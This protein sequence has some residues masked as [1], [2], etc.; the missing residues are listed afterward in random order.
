[1][2]TFF[3]VVCGLFCPFSASAAEQVSGTN[4]LVGESQ[5]WQTGETTGYWMTSN[6]G[7]RISD[8]PDQLP[9]P[10]ECHGAGHFDADGSWGEGICRF[11]DA[12]DFVLQSFKIEQGADTGVWEI[13]RTGGSYAGL[14]GSG[15]YR[16]TRGLGGTTVSVWEGETSMAE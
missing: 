9:R 7:V 5:V 1:M 8:D 12:T 13:L 2:R 4:Y 16:S 14:T 6:K 11:G 10:T 3:L 15:T